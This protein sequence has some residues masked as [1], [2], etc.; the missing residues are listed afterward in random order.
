MMSKENFS[1]PEFSIVIPN[2]NG[3]EFAARGISSLLISARAYGK[4][5]EMI[6]VD[7][8]STDAAPRI[9]AETFPDIHLLRN[10]QNKGFGASVNRGVAAAKAPIIVLANN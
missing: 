1:K 9:I 10:E 6:V 3:A 7:D 5:F 8:A 4:P 2:W